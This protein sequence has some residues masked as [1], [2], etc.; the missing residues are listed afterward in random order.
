MRAHG[1]YV[2]F[3]IDKD[4]WYFKTEYTYAGDDFKDPVTM[5]IGPLWNMKTTFLKQA[6]TD[7]LIADFGNIKGIDLINIDSANLPDLI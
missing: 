2:T 6:F 1:L 4:R 3:R 7:G 5:T